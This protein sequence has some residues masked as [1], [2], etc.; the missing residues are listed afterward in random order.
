MRHLTYESCEFDCIEQHFPG[1]ESI[2]LDPRDRDY[3]DEGLWNGSTFHASTLEFFRLNPQLHGLAITT[4]K[5]KKIELLRRTSEL[6]PSLE[7]LEIFRLESSKVE[8]LIH[9]NK[10][11]T[12]NLYSCKRRVMPFRFGNLE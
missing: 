3:S 9:F 10:V 6:L 4:Y 12:F 8:H 7:R 1:L 5:R 11:K 2:E